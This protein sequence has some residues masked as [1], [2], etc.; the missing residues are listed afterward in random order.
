MGIVSADIYALVPSHFLKTYPYISLYI[1]YQVPNVYWAVGV[2][3]GAG[4]QD[5]SLLIAHGWLVRDNYG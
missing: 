4:D 2:G 3:Q 1:L 5:F